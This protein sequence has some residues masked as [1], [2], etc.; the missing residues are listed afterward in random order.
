MRDVRL[1]SRVSVQQT[2]V[3]ATLVSL[4]TLGA[5]YDLEVALLAEKLK[6][7]TPQSQIVGMSLLF[8]IS[9]FVQPDAF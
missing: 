8:W 4:N 7:G 6:G 9:W 3:H 2:A 1:L 5:W